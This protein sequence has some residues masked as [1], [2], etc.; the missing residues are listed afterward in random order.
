MKKSIIVRIIVGVMAICLCILALIITYF[1]NTDIE[2]REPK[3]IIEEC[4]INT[5]CPP[6]PGSTVITKHI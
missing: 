4:E 5:Y 2:T 6:F 1:F 3:E